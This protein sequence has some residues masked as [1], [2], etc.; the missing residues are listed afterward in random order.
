MLFIQVGALDAAGKDSRAAPACRPNNGEVAVF[1]A[2][3]QCA[4]LR[5]G[6][7]RT[8][9][10]AGLGDKDIVSIKRGSFARAVVCGLDDR[11]EVECEDSEM[12]IKSRR[13]SERPWTFV[14]VARGSQELKCRP[15]DTEIAIFAA[16]QPIGP[17]IRLAAG[18][19]DTAEKI[20]L[21]RLPRVD[22]ISERREAAKGLRR[23]GTLLI[24][25]A[26]LHIRVGAGVQAKLCERENLGERCESLK[27]RR[28]TRLRLGSVRVLAYCQPTSTQVALFTQ[29]HALGYC[30]VRE[31]GEYPTAALLQVEGLPSASMRLG[32][33]VEARACSDEN[34]TGECVDAKG[35]AT[36]D[37]MKK[38]LVIRSRKNE[39]TP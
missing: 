2:D 11:F 32:S 22:F 16:S 35:A 18:T 24:A 4:V 33:G 13:R 31:I 10:E 15:S 3:G 9:A 25:G 36:I 17:C 5:A 6:T 30:T 19:Y 27:P 37:G 20:G 12:S 34:F 23:A 1:A 29:P 38:S 26:D 7:Y 28:S 39:A 14:Q 8:T 21:V